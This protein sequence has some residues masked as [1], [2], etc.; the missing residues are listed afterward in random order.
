MVVGSQENEMGINKASW[1]RLESHM[2]L[3]LPHS[4]GQS[5]LKASL[6]SRTPPSSGRGCKDSLAIFNWS[7]AYRQEI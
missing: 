1:S 5:R 2:I 6:D 7:Q 3:L 4:T